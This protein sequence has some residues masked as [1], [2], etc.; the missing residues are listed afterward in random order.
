MTLSSVVTKTTAPVAEEFMKK[1]TMVIAIVLMATFEA[2][3]QKFKVSCR[4]SAS[5]FGDTE[6]ISTVFDDST[7]GGSSVGNIG[8]YE[9]TTANIPFFAIVLTDSQGNKTHINSK[10]ASMV[11]LFIDNVTT[12]TFIG[13]SCDISKVN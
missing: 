2:Q 1:V 4:L 12:G 13:G 8:N 7:G 5:K 10:D 9:I 11:G 3:A 6:T